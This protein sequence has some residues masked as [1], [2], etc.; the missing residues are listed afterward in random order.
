MRKDGDG[1]FY[2]QCLSVFL[3]KTKQ[4]KQDKSELAKRGK[5]EM[6]RTINKLFRLCTHLHD[7]LRIRQ[8]MI[9]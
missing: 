7:S 9:K 6:G 5:N 8:F 3:E 4:D 1:I 2:F